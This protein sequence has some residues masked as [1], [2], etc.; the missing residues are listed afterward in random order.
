M[1]HQ[2][3]ILVGTTKGLFLLHSDGAREAW[4][5]TGPL[6]DGWA[7]NHATDDAATGTIWA[8]GGGEWSGAGVWRSEDG[9]A[10]WTV[11]KL[12]DGRM[13]PK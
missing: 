2:T 10:S 9:G 13:D 11:S 1:D 4:E 6:C 3:T 12:A 5:V 7:I 8:G